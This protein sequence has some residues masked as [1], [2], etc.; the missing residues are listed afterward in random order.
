[1]MLR[2]SLLILVA[3]TLAA[4][5]A[6]QAEVPRLIFPVVGPST[7]TNDFGAPRGSGRHEGVDIMAPKKSLAVAV[8]AGTVRFWTTSARA[9][10]MLYLHGKSGTSYLYIHL[11]NDRTLKNDNSGACVQGIAYARGLKNGA[12]VAAGQTIAYVGDSGD[13]NGGASHLHFEVH[14]NGGGAANPYRHLRSARELLFAPAPGS[15][16]FRLA[17]RGT[18]VSAAATTATLAVDRLV[19]YP[20]GL[21]V[22]KV[23]R[24]VE[25]AV[26]PETV[27]FNPLGALLAG[28]RLAALAAGKAAVV[29]TETQPTTLQAQ[30]GVPLSLT[31]EK[32]SLGS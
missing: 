30:L 15:D 21:Q 1:M 25:L 27:V 8:E 12:R 20:G 9:G 16:V 13:A 3:A 4:P 17:M 32:I 6:A 24:K 29:W 31:A 28:A 26:S 22:T 11:N 5:A 14:P 10:C 18:V 7:Y 19:R 2:R 23:D